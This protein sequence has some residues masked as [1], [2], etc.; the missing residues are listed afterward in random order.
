MWPKKKDDLFLD[1]S[2]KSSNDC[3]SEEDEKVEVLGDIAKKP[4]SKHSQE[5]LFTK[6]LALQN[7]IRELK[8]SSNLKDDVSKLKAK[9]NKLSNDLK[10]DK[11]K[12]VTLKKYSLEISKLKNNHS[13]QLYK[14]K[15]ENDKKQ[16][17]IAEK[18]LE[19]MK[20]EVEIDSL[21]QCKSK[22]K[23]RD[24]LIFQKLCNK[25][26]KEMSKDRQLQR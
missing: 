3:K 9:I 12:N 1:L 8:E 23:S 2:S 17:T 19:I 18:D 22:A 14:Q 13:I 7:E 11:S 20:R 6:N 15:H 25:E 4:Q 16:L 21:C 24:K 26:K 10:E 5:D